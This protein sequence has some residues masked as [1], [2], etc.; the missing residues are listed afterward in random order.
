MARLHVDGEHLVVALG[1]LD[2]MLSVRSTMR[3]PL[4]CV[5]NVYVDPVIAEEPRGVKAP[6]THIPGVCTKGTF[7]FDGVKTF[8]SVLRGTDAIVVELSGQKVDRLVIEQSNP[9]AIVESI[10]TA[11]N[12]LQ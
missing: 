11:K 7:H 12:F 9:E 2:T 1:L 10:L 4:S 3:F 6:G 5:T 8:W